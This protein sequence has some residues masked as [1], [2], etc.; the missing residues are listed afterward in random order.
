MKTV[1][2][3]TRTWKK[4][5]LHVQRSKQGEKKRRRTKKTRRWKQTKAKGRAREPSKAKDDR[6]ILLHARLAPADSAKAYDRADRMPTK[7]V[8]LRKDT[9]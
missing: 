8:T 1:S 7:V 9:A 6:G 2:V 4:H 3:V 5:K